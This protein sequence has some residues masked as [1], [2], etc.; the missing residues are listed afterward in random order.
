[1]EMGSCELAVL[2]ESLLG[3]KGGRVDDAYAERGDVKSP[4]GSDSDL[5]PTLGGKQ[6]LF[7]RLVSEKM[8]L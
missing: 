4:R 3:S 5:V 7:S 6:S 8:L 1:M 2:A